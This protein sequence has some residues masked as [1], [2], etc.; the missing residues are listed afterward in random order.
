M[1]AGA[2]PL[3]GARS[4]SHPPRVTGIEALAFRAPRGHWIEI[5]TRWL[6]PVLPGIFIS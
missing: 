1:G 5:S 2:T 4:A 6:S 3:N